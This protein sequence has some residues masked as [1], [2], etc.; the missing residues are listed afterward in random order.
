MTGLVLLAALFLSHYLADFCLTTRSM[1]VAKSDGKTLFPIIFHAS[2][3][4]LL[5]GICLFIFGTTIQMLLGLFLL[6]FISHFIIDTI[7]GRLTHAY[8]KLADN[9]QKPYWIVY[10]MD[11]LL[12]QLIIITIWGIAIASKATTSNCHFVF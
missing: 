5:M 1:I 6:E 11:Q 4:A 7:K 10:G 3:H 12:H 8:P 9:H 2:I